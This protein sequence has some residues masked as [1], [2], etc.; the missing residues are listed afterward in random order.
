MTLKQRM[1]NISARA[2]LA[3]GSKCFRRIPMRTGKGWLS[4]KTAQVISRIAKLEERLMPVSAAG[5]KLNFWLSPS[6]VIGAFAALCGSFEIVEIEA[7]LRALARRARP[8]LLDVGA[9]AG[10]YSIFAAAARTRARCVAVEADPAAA[11]RLRRNLEVNADAI[12]RNASSVDVV[13]AALSGRS[14]RA[15][16]WRSSDDAQGSLCDAAGR[17]EES[18]T[19]RTWRGDELLAELGVEHVDFCKIDVEGGELLVLKGLE[20]T[21]RGKRIDLLQVELNKTRSGRA[22]HS[23]AAIVEF[24]RDRGYE[25]AA[26]SRTRYRDARWKCENFMFAKAAD[27]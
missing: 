24:L 3:V 15:R 12:L 13:E 8:V 6:S 2:M 14:G 7:C 25:M 17:S 19:V 27:A 5:L 16:F 26:G 9:N 4:A 22:G 10:L 23:C 18:V 1:G 11:A 20:G 21:L